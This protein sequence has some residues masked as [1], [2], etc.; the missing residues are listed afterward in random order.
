MQMKR[1][2]KILG[3]IG[4]V[5]LVVYGAFSYANHRSAVKATLTWARLAPYP[6]SVEDFKLTTEG[7]M[8]TRAFR[9]SFSMP[10]SELEKWMNDS[11]G[12]RDVAPTQE[13]PNIK[14]YIQTPAAEGA[15]YAEIVIDLDRNIVQIY[16]Y[17]S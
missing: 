17:W 16:T 13:G 15:Q 5:V 14:K 2:T 11:P 4:I 9:V 1:R 3:I 7:S 10:H 8:F 6:S 12:I